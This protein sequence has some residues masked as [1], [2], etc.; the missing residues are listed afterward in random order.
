ML[1]NKK[2][3]GTNSTGPKWMKQTLTELR[4]EIALQ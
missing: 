2:D 3:D 4:E 1:S